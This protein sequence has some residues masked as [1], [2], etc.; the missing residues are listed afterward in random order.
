[1]LGTSDCS[2]SLNEFLIRSRPYAG[3]RSPLLLP[4]P[5]R[6]GAMTVI[7]PPA[8]ALYDGSDAFPV[9]SGPAQTATQRTVQLVVTGVIVVGPFAGVVAALWLLWGTYAGLADVGLAAFLYLVTGFGATAGFHRCLTHRSFVARP[10]LRV[11][12]AVAG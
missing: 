5:Q 1:M 6:G 11:A 8:T 10:A 12:L 3:P 2:G 4:Y 9:S 7:T